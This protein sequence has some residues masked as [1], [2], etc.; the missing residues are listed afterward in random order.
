M[1]GKEHLPLPDLFS[2]GAEMTASWPELRRASWNERRYSSAHPSSL[3]WMMR[4]PWLPPTASAT[5]EAI[6]NRERTPI[7]RLV[8]E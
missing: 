1:S 2:A 4:I 7:L 6:W 3:D 5:I 8:G